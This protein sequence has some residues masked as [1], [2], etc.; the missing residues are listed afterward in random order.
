MRRPERRSRA[1]LPSSLA[2]DRANLQVREAT[3]HEIVQMIQRMYDNCLFVGVIFERQLLVLLSH[4]LR[5][6]Y[7]WHF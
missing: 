1:R 3:I 2:G 6:D 7:F 4:C 5:G